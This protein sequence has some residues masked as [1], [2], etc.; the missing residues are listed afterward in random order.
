M[1]WRKYFSI[2]F[3]FQNNSYIANPNY[4]TVYTTQGQTCTYEATSSNFKDSNESSNF[5]CPKYI[6]RLSPNFFQQF[7]KSDSI[8]KRLK[9]HKWQ[10]Q[11]ELVIQ[12]KSVLQVQQEE[13]LHHCAVP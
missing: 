4:P 3:I 13:I 12:I 10:L 6:Q 2:N 5:L 1:Y 11:P 9:L 7:A 8:L